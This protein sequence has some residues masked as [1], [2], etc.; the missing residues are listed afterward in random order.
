MW[1]ALES[2]HKTDV[3]RLHGLSY[4]AAHAGMSP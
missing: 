4:G 1:L 2:V 3:R